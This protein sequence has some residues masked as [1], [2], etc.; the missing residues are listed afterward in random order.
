M[1]SDQTTVGALA[2]MSLWMSDTPDPVISG[3]YLT[4]TLNT[5]NPGPSLAVGVTISDNLPPPLTFISSGSS[6][7]CGVNSGIVTCSLGNLSPGENRQVVIRTLVSPSYSGTVT[8]AAQV[9]SSISDPNLTNNHAEVQTT[10]LVPD[11]I[12]PTVNWVQPVQN[13]GLFYVGCQIVHLGVTA[14][15]NV[16]I[17]TCCICLV[18]S[19]LASMVGYRH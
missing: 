9:T 8:N 11:E 5:T 13:E 14:T 2:D 18:G 17:Q 16:A 4:Y 19:Y 12:P 6:P 1:A 7:A 15:D 10:V 3:N